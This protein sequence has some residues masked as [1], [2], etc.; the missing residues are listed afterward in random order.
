MIQCKNKYHA[1]NALPRKVY[2]KEL[3]DLGLLAKQL[4]CYLKKNGYTIQEFSDKLKLIDLKN[5]ES[6]LEKEFAK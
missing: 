4:N 1:L 5:T 3:Y 2:K 6:Y